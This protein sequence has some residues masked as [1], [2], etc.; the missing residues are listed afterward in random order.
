MSR[1]KELSQWFTP[2]WAARAIVEMKLPDL[3]AG[4]RVLEPSCGTGRFLAALPDELE[5]VGVEIDQD[6]AAIARAQG[7]GHVVTGDFRSCALPHDRYDAI[8][9]NPPFKLEVFD[10]FMERSETLL[11]EGSRAV[12]VLPSYAFQ[13]T[14]R[15][16]RWN[17][18]WTIQQ[19]MLPRTLFPGIRLPLTLATFI[20]D[21]QPRLHGFL[22]YAQSREVEEMPAIYKKALA[23][24]KSG[25]RAV[26]IH[27]LRQSGGEATVNEICCRIAPR[28]PT[29]TQHWREKVRQHL[30]DTDHFE[31]T[32]PAT[33]RLKAA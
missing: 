32:A 8:I 15:V 27:A 23:E 25:W 13:T 3:P 20:R 17:R 31:R 21:S 26:V 19:E 9:G 14:N 22:L 10:G 4:A 2:L 6:V 33:Y 18:K 1:Q 29:A 24:Q 7:R 16:M 28:R 11:E 5:I 30:Q 12:Y